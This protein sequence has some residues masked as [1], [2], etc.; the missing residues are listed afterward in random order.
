MLCL[1]AS[2]YEGFSAARYI[3]NGDVT[4]VTHSGH[5]PPLL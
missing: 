3:F 2:I 5:A 4:R 1:G